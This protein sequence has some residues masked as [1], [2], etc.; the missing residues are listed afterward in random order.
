MLL[1]WQL[2]KQR[3]TVLFPL[4]EKEIPILVKVEPVEI[5]EPISEADKSKSRYKK[6]IPPVPPSPVS[7]KCLFNAYCLYDSTTLLHSSYVIDKGKIMNPPAALCRRVF[8]RNVFL[9]MTLKHVHYHLLLLFS[10]WIWLCVWCVAAGEMKTVCCCVTAVTAAITL[11]AWSLL[12]TTSPRETGG[13]PSVW[14]RWGG[15]ERD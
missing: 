4:A 13:A 12:C 8:H 6:F 10:R 15:T 14:L 11:S 7:R 5:K 2:W 1:L 3:L 9:A